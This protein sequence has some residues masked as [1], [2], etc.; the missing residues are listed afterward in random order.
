MVIPGGDAALPR[1]WALAATIVL[2]VLL[3]PA[4]VQ[5]H[6]D[7]GN[8]VARVTAITPAVPGLTAQVIFRDD[9]LL[10]TNATGGEVQ[11]F[12]YD[13]EPYLRLTPAAVYA[14]RRSPAFYI[15]ADPFNQ[16]QAPPGTDP[17]ATPD[18]TRV[19]DTNTYAWH[20]RRIRWTGN[21]LPPAVRANPSKEQ[22]VAR[23]EV[24]G[25]AGVPFVIQGELSWVPDRDYSTWLGMAVVMLGLLSLAAARS[26]HPWERGARAAG[27]VALVASGLGFVLALLLLTGVVEGADASR[28]LATA[29]LAFLSGVPAVRLRHGPGRS[30]ALWLAA[31]LAALAAFA[32]LLHADLVSNASTA[33]KGGV[34]AAA[35]VIATGAMAGCL[36]L[37]LLL[38][39]RFARSRAAPSLGAD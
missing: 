18:W 19:A 4:G 20:D 15:N 21:D 7:S 37:Y 6:G 36:S 34:L 5:A 38:S 33:A 27:I 16:V 14:N 1:R 35:L 22:V 32:G 31:A 10:L 11:V 9:Q 3:A 29:A 26:I 12:G 2:C 25:A 13:G 17:R 39:L 30:S 23:W 28:E 24:A 8:Y